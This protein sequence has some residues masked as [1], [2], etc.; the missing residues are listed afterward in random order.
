MIV[1]KTK[2]IH[3]EIADAIERSDKIIDGYFDSIL[4]TIVTV[5]EYNYN[6]TE[7]GQYIIDQ[8]KQHV[9]PITMTAIGATLTYSFLFSGFDPNDIAGIFNA[10]FATSVL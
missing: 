10:E 2:I 9:I 3:V 4:A 7:V 1:T 5:Q 6:R 8:V